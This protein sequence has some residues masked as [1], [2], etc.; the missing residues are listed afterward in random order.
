MFRF[1]GDLRDIHHPVFVAIV[2]HY[3]FTHVLPTPNAQCIPSVDWFA[4]CIARHW[5]YIQR[6]RVLITQLVERDERGRVTKKHE[7][8][9]G[10][11]KQKPVTVEHSETFYG[12]LLILHRVFGKAEGARLPWANNEH[13]LKMYFVAAFTLAV[14]YC[15]DGEVS[16]DHVHLTFFHEL[17]Q[18][19]QDSG[20]NDKAERRRKTR[21]TLNELEWWI[22]E[23]LRFKLL[24]LKKA[25]AERFVRWVEREV[26]GADGWVAA[27]TVWEYV[28][29]EGK[30]MKEREEREERKERAKAERSDK[31]WPPRPPTPFNL[32]STKPRPRDHETLA[33][34]AQHT[35]MSAQPTKTLP[36]P[37]TD[38]SDPRT[39]DSK[40]QRLQGSFSHIWLKEARCRAHPD[41]MGLHHPYF[42]DRVIR[43]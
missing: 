36:D 28:E 7:K 5:W 10:L 32:P 25:T 18:P 43:L 4:G 40:N 20:R 9:S 3:F 34:H 15:G 39:A 30:S 17:S 6:H 41:Y 16:D 14:G 19:E 8:Q 24:F 13:A 27:I 26:R 35:R 31:G 37:R 1:K 22:F 11:W 2:C 23:S 12:A 38:L 33:L 42:C 21:K 29:K